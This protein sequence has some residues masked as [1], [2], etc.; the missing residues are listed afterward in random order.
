VSIIARPGMRPVTIRVD[1]DRALRDR[2]ERIL[3][4]RD[5]ILLQERP[6]EGIARYLSEKFNIDIVYSS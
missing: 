1:L 2:R 3:S 5:L 4:S 6:E